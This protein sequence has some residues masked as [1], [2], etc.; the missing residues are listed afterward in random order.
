MGSRRTSARQDG[1]RTMTAAATPPGSRVYAIGDIHG[2]LDLLLEL[3]ELI[4][5]DAARSHAKR[6]VLVYIGDYID[7]GPD[8]AGV[9]D[10]L[11]DRP[12][13]DF[14]IVHL[15]GNH[16]DTLL[17]FP[18]DITV[19]PSWLTYGG[20]QTLASYFI[21]V[22]PGSWCDE[23]E[24]RRLQG[25]I[26]RRVPHR[27][28]EFMRGLP[29]THIEG[30]YLFV[31]AGIRPGV[32]LEHQE[33]DDLLWIRDEFLRSPADHGKIVVHGHTITEAPDQQPNR[34]GIDTGAFHTDRLTCVVLE[35]TGRAFLQT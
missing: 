13:P 2:R 34:I 29:L 9:L 12:L 21:D 33:R 19:G 27:H 6:R 5:A 24:L 17:Q 25:E 23:R 10:L 16:E 8:S 11:L 4:A 18:D 20:V 35:G 14:K 7:R 31:H 22:A 32:P 3:H 28:V 26:R 1:L 15:L 30:D